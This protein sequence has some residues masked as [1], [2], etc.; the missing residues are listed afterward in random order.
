MATSW[1]SKGR[2]DPP[3]STPRQRWCAL[4][5]LDRLT[6][7]TCEGQIRSKPFGFRY[8]E[9]LGGRSFRA[10][11]LRGGPRSVTAQASE[12]RE[13][14]NRALRDVAVPLRRTDHPLWASRKPAVQA[15]RRCLA[16]APAARDSNPK[17]HIRPWS[18]CARGHHLGGV[19]G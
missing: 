15:A 5:S 11:L 8:L 18:G 13:C 1:Q 3:C 12:L 14:E 10:Q 16:I 17:R 6:G 4:D 9:V 7:P 19:L 2:R